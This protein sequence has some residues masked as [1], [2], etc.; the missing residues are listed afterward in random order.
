MSLRNRVRLVWITLIVLLVVVWLRHSTNFDEPWDGLSAFVVMIAGIAI[1]NV[2]ARRSLKKFR[3]ALSLGDTPTA[4]REHANLADFW[5]RRGREMIKAYSVNILLLEEQYQDALDVLQTLN[6]GKLGKKGRP[7]VENQIA[8]C[9]AHLGEPARAVEISRAALPRL[10]SMGPDCSAS[11]HLVL[12]T[13]NFLSG[14]CSEAV[15]DLQQACAA[16]A[17]VPSRRAIAAF[18]LGEAFSALGRSTEAQ[19]AYRNAHEALPTGRF[20]LRAL[21]R[22][23]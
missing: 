21:E 5:K 3:K 11:G 13:A 18:Y 7:V 9:K 12:G 19:K 2:L 8:C 17:E 10:E 15:P 6:T 1:A 23:K 22:F 14:R 4:K 20:G 16:S